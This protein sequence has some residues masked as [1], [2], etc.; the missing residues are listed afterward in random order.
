MDRAEF[1][2]MFDGQL[3]HRLR[4]ELGCKEAFPEAYDKICRSARHWPPSL[5]P[6]HSP[7]SQAHQG[8]VYNSRLVTDTS[9]GM[10][11]KGFTQRYISEFST[12]KISFPHTLKQA[13]TLLFG[14]LAVYEE[15]PP[16][17]WNSSTRIIMLLMKNLFF[18]FS[19]YYFIIHGLI[20][21]A[22]WLKTTCNVYLLRAYCTKCLT[23][24]F[25]FKNCYYLTAQ[26]PYTLKTWP[27]Y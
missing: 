15:D 18:P 22:S 10:L 1:W 13:K 25:F 12:V 8:T 20:S 23:F 19:V 26:V 6:D 21:S 2:E 17:V 4:E 11:K 7:V 27:P 5:L 9:V 16:S 14:D 3:Y 24:Y